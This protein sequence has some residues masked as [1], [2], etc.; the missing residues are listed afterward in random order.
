MA[1]ELFV[2]LTN[3]DNDYLIYPCLGKLELFEFGV[4]GSLILG[5]WRGLNKDGTFAAPVEV[6]RATFSYNGGYYQ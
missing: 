2:T 6:R 1:K 3:S 4:N 5:V